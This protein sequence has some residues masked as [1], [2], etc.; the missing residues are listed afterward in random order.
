[1]PFWRLFYHLVWTTKQREPWLTPE[2]EPVIHDLLRAKAIGLGATV[3]AL[4]GTVDHVHH[5]ALRA[6]RFL[7]R[8]IQFGYNGPA[9]GRLSAPY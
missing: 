3:F 8:A 1:M 6:A 5:I 7:A 4:N 2:V 9:V